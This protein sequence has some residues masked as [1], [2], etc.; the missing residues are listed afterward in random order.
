M[1]NIEYQKDVVMLTNHLPLWL[2][3]E[4][5]QPVTHEDLTGLG[6]RAG[7]CIPYGY[8]CWVFEE[9]DWQWRTIPEELKIICLWVREHC[10]PDTSHIVFDR[11]GEQME[12]LTTFEW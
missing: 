1:S 5:E 8:R 10:D 9:E 4:W 6:A 3:E 7:Y 12:G 2:A 11:D